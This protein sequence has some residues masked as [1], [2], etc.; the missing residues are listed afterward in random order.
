MVKVSRGVLTW[1]N[2]SI[3]SSG[4]EKDTLVVVEEHMVVLEEKIVE[5]WEESNE[6]TMVALE[7]IEML[8]SN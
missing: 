4:L 5:W 8:D 3:N 2:S 1:T 6:K 7:I